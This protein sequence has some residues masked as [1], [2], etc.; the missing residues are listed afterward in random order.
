MVWVLEG[1][2]G[3]KTKK[4]DLPASGIESSN[5]RMEATHDVFSF[6]QVEGKQT[7]VKFSNGRA[8]SH[9]ELNA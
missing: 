5:L 9:V 4:C 6:L 7:R 1:P 3:A 2:P 8:A